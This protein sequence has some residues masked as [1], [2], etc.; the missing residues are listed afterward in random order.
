LNHTPKEIGAIIADN[1]GGEQLTEFDLARVKVPSGGGTTWEVPTLG[2]LEPTKALT[3]VLVHFKRTRAYWA[4]DADSGTPPQC[5]SEG[6]DLTAVGTGDPG[7]PC[8][9]CP[10][11]EFGTAVDD[12]GRPAPGQACNSKEIWFLLR[13]G[14][15]LPIVL[16]LPATSLK[17]AGAYRKRTLGGVGIRYSSVVTSISLTATKNAKGDSYASSPR[18]SPASSTPRRPGARRRTA[19]S[20]APCSTLP[21]TRPP[22]TRADGRGRLSQPPCGARTVALAASARLRRQ[23]TRRGLCA[24][25]PVPEVSAGWLPGADHQSHRLSWALKRRPRLGRADRGTSWPLNSAPA[26]S[27]RGGGRR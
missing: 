8:I 26:R 15:Y 5:R 4:P 22:R 27:R 7:G 14:D 2:G 21:R 9:T 6:P 25:L 20:S 10:H 1:L 18:P 19:T 17:A 24:S 11:A 3:G 23:H 16:A 13:E 12:S